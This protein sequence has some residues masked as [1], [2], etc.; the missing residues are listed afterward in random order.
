[1]QKKLILA[2]AVMAVGALLSGCIRLQTTQKKLNELQSGED[3]NTILK[4]FGSPARVYSGS[5]QFK[6]RDGTGGMT[7]IPFQIWDYYVNKGKNSTLLYIYQGRLMQVENLQGHPRVPTAGTV[8]GEGLPAA[9]FE[10]DI[11]GR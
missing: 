1:M 8:V 5:Y 9:K 7:K 10:I 6:R 2:V 3:S 11:S 4:N